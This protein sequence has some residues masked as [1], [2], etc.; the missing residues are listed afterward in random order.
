MTTLEAFDRTL[1]EHS[2]ADGDAWSDD[3]AMLLSALAAHFGAEDL[4]GLPSIWPDRP[5][6]WQR[7]CAQVLGSV[8]HDQ[9]IELHVDMVERGA[10]TVE[11]AALETL[12]EFDPGV[13]SPEQ[14]DRITSA[15]ETLLAKPTAALHQFLLEKFLMRLR[16]AGAAAE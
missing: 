10:P 6:F 12:S 11:I 7:H 1:A 8:R 14:A 4:E 15:V 9:A 5:R 16:S 3:G 13:L 2:H